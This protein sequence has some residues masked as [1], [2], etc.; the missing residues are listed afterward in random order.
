MVNYFID[1]LVFVWVFVII[2]MFVGGL[3]IMNLS[4]V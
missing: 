4:V 3:A 1:R 2:M